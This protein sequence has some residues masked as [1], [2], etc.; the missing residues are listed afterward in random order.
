MIGPTEK[1]ESIIA[2]RGDFNH[3][4]GSVVE[5][6]IFNN[7]FGI[8]AICVFITLCLGWSACQIKI[9]ASYSAMLPSKQEYIVNYQKNREGMRAL[10]DSIRVIVQ[11]KSGSIYNKNY[12]N[13]LREINDAIFLLPGVDR[14]FM[15]SLWQPTVRWTE[16]TPSGTIGGPVMPGTY[17][18]SAEAIKQLQNNIFQAGIIGSVVGNDLKSSSIFVP[19]LDIDPRTGK[20]FNY[21]KFWTQ[22]TAI[23]DKYQTPD[24]EVRI[25]GFAAIMGY[26]IA[27]LHEIVGFFLISAAIASFFIFMFTRCIRSTIVIISCS[28]V[29]VIWLLGIIRFFGYYLDPYSILVPFLVFAIGVSHGAQK[30]NGIMQD[31][32]RGINK[33]VAA[34]Y[35]FRRLFIAGLT[36]LLADAIGFAVLM[37]ISIQSIRTLALTAS[38]GVSMLIFTN[39]VLLPVILS[40][41]GVSAKA[42]ARSLQAEQ[43]D[44]KDRGP[45]AHFFDFLEHFTHSSWA[46]KAVAVA[47][48]LIVG[49]YIVG[50]HVQI[51][52]VSQGAP[53]LR[54]HS[55]YNLDN[56]YIMSHYALSS[57]QFAV[58][59][60]GNMADGRGLVSYPAMIEMDRLEQKMR[61]VPGVQTTVSIADYVRDDTAGMFEDNLKWWTINRQEDVLAEA[62]DDAYSARPDLISNDFSSAP[63]IIYLQ[64]HKAKTLNQVA[65]VAENFAK[66]HSTKDVKFML[67]AGNAGFDEA[68]NIIVARSDKIM[69][70]LVYA[71]VILLCF[72]SFRSWRAVVVAIVPLVITSI[73]CQ[74][75]MVLMNIGITVSTLP[76]IALGVGIGVDYALY[77][78]SV[79]LVF[80]RQGISLREAYR[81]SLRFTGRI[82][83]LVGFTLAAGVSIWAFSPIQFQADMGIL[84]TFMFLWNMVGALILIPA[85]SSFLLRTE[86]VFRK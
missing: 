18:G 33:Y 55:A 14:S 66:Q 6:L 43:E 73:L 44:K 74:A 49:G 40:Y 81:K 54:P 20:A 5:R 17:N 35:T 45:V 2:Q 13:V 32:G 61:S 23:K 85:L 56:A 12:L 11:T 24:I 41:L 8:I 62:I 79:Q 58:I 37:V 42:A 59:V 63:V 71:A 67:A 16:V 52:D 76:V 70:F 78:L 29:A 50:Q 1:S 39:L 9:N 36:A 31:I 46:K 19:L 64:N 34:R 21:G 47:F 65:N 3:Y 80:Q 72:I 30:M 69:P 10:G 4:S 25:V 75:L 7:R 77:L 26:L 82:V 48:T 83:V 57:D 27:A 60:K 51:G 53:E 84:L 22:L 28:F 86:S 38:I 68:T 15:T